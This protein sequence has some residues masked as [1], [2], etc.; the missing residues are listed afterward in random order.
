[1]FV[2]LFVLCFSWSTKKT[3]I[4]GYFVT[5]ID[6]VKKRS[7]LWITLSWIILPG[8][9]DLRKVTRPKSGAK[10]GWSIV[11]GLRLV[12]FKEFNESPILVWVFRFFP[13]SFNNSWVICISNS[14]VITYCLWIFSSIGVFGKIFATIWILCSKFSTNN[15]DPL[16]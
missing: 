13:L 2:H 1:M 10:G 15:R 11:F 8:K 14:R 7:A 3:D 4:F 5:S 12:T 16:L 6:Y 9:I